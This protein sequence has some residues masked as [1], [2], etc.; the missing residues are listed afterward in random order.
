MCTDR[1]KTVLYFHNK[2]LPFLCF[3]SCILFENEMIFLSYLDRL[4]AQML[5][6]LNKCYQFCMDYS[7]NI[8]MEIQLETEHIMLHWK[9]LDH[10]PDM[11][12]Y[13]ASRFIVLYLLQALHL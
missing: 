8:Y 13:V 1:S 11:T 5:N 2:E 4:Q 3:P 10:F 12:F 9:L 6:I 7:P